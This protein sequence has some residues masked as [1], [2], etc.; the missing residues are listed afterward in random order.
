MVQC[1]MKILSY[2]SIIYM[3][4]KY[5]TTH[6]DQPN[7]QIICGRKRYQGRHNN[8]FPY[9]KKSMAVV[10]SPGQKNRVPFSHP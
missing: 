1:I 7:N 4:L 5:D 8:T 3:I 9:V 10:F 2:T 6:Y